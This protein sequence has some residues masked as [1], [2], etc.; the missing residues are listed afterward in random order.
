MEQAPSPDDR[1]D[2]LAALLAAVRRGDQDALDAIVGEYYEQVE[3]AVHRRLQ[4]RFRRQGNVMAAMFSTGDIVHTVFLKV[5]S[6]QLEL[7][8]A[9]PAQFVAYLT[10]AVETQIVDQTRFHQAARRDRRLHHSPT[11]SGDRL[12]QVHTPGETPLEQAWSN[13]QQ[14][15]YT[16]VLASFDDRDRNLLTLRIEARCSFEEI[17]NRLGYNTV[18]AARKAFHSAKARLLVRL[19]A[20]GIEVENVGRTGDG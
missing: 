1:P 12:Q 16:E 2:D 17:S 19:G 15:I 18:D 8:D 7:D 4:L 13:E 20:R 9:R 14:R 3:R 5:L 11:E 6:G 10:K